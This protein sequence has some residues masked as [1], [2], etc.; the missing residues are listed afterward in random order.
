MHNMFVYT[1]SESDKTFGNTNTCALITITEVSTG[2][3]KTFDD[4]TYF[5]D[6][7]DEEMQYALAEMFYD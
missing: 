3:T 7:G 5:E 4:F 1:I 2:K 6:E